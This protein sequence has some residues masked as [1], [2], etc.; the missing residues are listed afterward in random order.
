MNE[1]TVPYRSFR[2]VIFPLGLAILLLAARPARAAQEPLPDDFMPSSQV[3][4]G[5]IGEGRTVFHG[6]KVEPF[7]VQIL[8]VQHNNMAGCDLILAKLDGPLLEKHGVVAGMSGSPVFI[9]GKLI[10]AVSYG[11][12]YAYAPYCGITPIE[13]MWTVWQSIGEPA[14]AEIHDN[15][16]LPVSV[17]G[18]SVAW[19]WE[20]AWHRYQQMMQGE[21]AGGGHETTS[22]GFRPDLPELK[23]VQGEMR[24]VFSPMFVSS[25]SPATAR[26]LH[27]FFASRGV[28][29]MSAGSLSGSGGGSGPAEEAPEIEN[30]SALG[31]PLLSGDMSLAGVGTVTYRKGNKLIAFGHPMFFKGGTSAP[32]AQAYILGFMQSYERSFK[33]GDVRDV[34]GTIDQDR[35]FAIGGKLGESPSRVPIT[36]QVRGSGCSRPRTYHFSCWKNREY[37]PTMSASAAQE[38]YSASVAEGGDLTAKVAYDV[39]LAD[40]RLIHKEFFESDRGSVISQPISAMLFDMFL[41]EENPFH[42]ADIKSIEMTVDVTPGV[43]QDQLVSTRLEHA[44]CRPGDRVNVVGRFR[45]WHGEEYERSFGMDLPRDLAPGNYV[46]HLTDSQGAMRVE[47]ANH[48]CCYAPR[49]FDGVVGLIQ[50]SDISDDEL[51]LYLFEPATD[52]NIN[53]FAMDRLPVSMGAMMQTTAPPQTQ[54]QS[55]GRELACQVQHAGVLVIGS[56][57]LVLQVSNHIDE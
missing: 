8:G 13:Q 36:V 4:P 7:K 35:L 27:G 3:K 41:L 42:E 44:T 15:G 52:L 47:R 1:K 49:D 53:G 25:A 54:Y 14:L 12:S 9:D 56:Q 51:R 23:G 16:P 19:D 5:M 20:P 21:K 18:A 48:P 43:H 10:G 11:W 22:A 55:V 37:V 50:N 31:V 46:L 26:L 2:R 39:K 32:M 40:G 33:L 24:P 34:V 6:Y 17:D 29:L 28:E 38:A 57:S 45:P 30:G